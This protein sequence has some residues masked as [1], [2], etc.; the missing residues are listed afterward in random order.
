MNQANP[1]PTNIKP[2]DTTPDHANTVASVADPTKA[3]EELGWTA[4]Q[5]ENR[6]RLILTP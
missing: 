5:D 6:V 4:E 1:L 2:G 3:N